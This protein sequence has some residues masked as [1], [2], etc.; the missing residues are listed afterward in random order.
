MIDWM[1]ESLSWGPKGLANWFIGSV[2]AAPDE[3]DEVIDREAISHAIHETES[4]RLKRGPPPSLF[5]LAQTIDER[6]TNQTLER[7]QIELV[8]NWRRYFMLSID[9]PFVPK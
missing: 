8:T 6:Y 5:A 2:N 3:I 1:N 4:E 9:L 7:R